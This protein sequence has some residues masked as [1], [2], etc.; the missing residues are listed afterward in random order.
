MPC[1][2]R[3][4]SRLGA[5][6]KSL[7]IS[8]KFLP[9]CANPENVHPS[10]RVL[11]PSFAQE[12]SKNLHILAEQYILSTFS[13]RQISASGNNMEPVEAADVPLA[14][15]II[16]VMLSMLT[17]GVLAVCLSMIYL[18]LMYFISTNQRYSP[19]TSDYQIM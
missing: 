8:T 13:I 10:A 11:R 4:R 5:H 9:L 6:V 17:F 7:V 18:S 14:G 12:H 2:V 19:E 3:F 15:N 1:R 16:S